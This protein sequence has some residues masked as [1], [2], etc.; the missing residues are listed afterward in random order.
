[1]R[2]FENMSVKDAIKFREIRVEK[3][4]KDINDIQMKLNQAKENAEEL[5]QSLDKLKRCS[6]ELEKNN[7]DVSVLTIRE[8]KHTSV[9]RDE[10]RNNKTKW[11]AGIVK[12]K[13]TNES[14]LLVLIPQASGGGTSFDSNVK[15]Y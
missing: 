1:M 4:I 14:E 2:Q 3:A 13:N 11:Y 9:W 7:M 10:M 15:L 8:L 12:N 6:A 5:K